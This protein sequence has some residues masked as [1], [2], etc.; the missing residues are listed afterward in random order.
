MSLL[1][2]MIRVPDDVAQEMVMLARLLRRGY[3]LVNWTYDAAR[4]H[5]TLFELGDHVDLP[6]RLVDAASRAAASVRAAPFEVTFDRLEAW[7]DALVLRCDDG[8]SPLTMLR[9]QLGAMLKR[10]GLDH[11][12]DFTPH[13]SLM[14]GATPVEAQHVKAFRWTVEAVALVNSLSGHGKYVELG[15]WP[16]RS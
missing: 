16:L 14:R 1:L 10:V 7:A 12:S 8:S 5:V 6:P 2:F 13:V 15:R 9:A 4:L 3:G 11:R